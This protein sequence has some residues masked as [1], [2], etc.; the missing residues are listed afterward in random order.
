MSP[1]F[2]PVKRRR[3][4]D[5]RKALNIRV[6]PRMNALLQKVSRRSGQ[7][8]SLIVRKYIREGLGREG[9]TGES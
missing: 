5:P 1:E 3:R 7:P 4:S 9:V 2:L 8:V 6:P